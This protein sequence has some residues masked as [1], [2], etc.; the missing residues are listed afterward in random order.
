MS[1][2]T[3]HRKARTRRARM[4][5]AHARAR[6]GARAKT[7]MRH[8]VARMFPARGPPMLAGACI[9]A[10]RLAHTDVLASGPPVRNGTARACATTI[11]RVRERA[12]VCVPG[13]VS[14]AAGHGAH[15]ERQELL[16]EVH[17]QPAEHVVV[18]HLHLHPVL[19]VPAAG[20][21][22]RACACVRVR[23]RSR[24]CMHARVRA[25]VSRCGQVRARI[26]RT[27]ARRT[28]AHACK[29][30]CVAWRA[31]AAQRQHA[32]RRG[33]RGRGAAAN[34]TEA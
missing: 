9:P 17:E 21:A 8:A 11:V 6:A 23:A 4:P 7:R 34:T 13:A 20:H 30:A 27:H 29:R 18:V 25:R 14:G 1:H 32:P 26:V 22:G 33:G 3:C 12:R 5:C 16:R 19:Q 15:H 24:A 31:R 28:R 10:R 2:I